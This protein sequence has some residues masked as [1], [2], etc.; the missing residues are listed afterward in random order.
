MVD[1][2]CTPLASQGRVDAH[3]H[4]TWPADNTTDFNTYTSA[5]VNFLDFFGFHLDTID[6]VS[7]LVS[8]LG[9]QKS[10]PRRTIGEGNWSP[11]GRRSGQK[12]Q[13]KQQQQQR[14]QTANKRVWLEVFTNGRSFVRLFF[15]CFIP[16]INVLH[17]GRADKGREEANE[18]R[19]GGWADLGRAKAPRID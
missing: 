14:R 16:L 12:Q 5:Q 18:W 17:T 7:I 10:P 9:V 13:Q 15:G 1:R 6:Q 8:S 4:C 3:V 2:K 11:L 19:G